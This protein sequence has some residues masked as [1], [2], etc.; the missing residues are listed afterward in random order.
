M[1]SVA[2]EQSSAHIHPWP[3][4]TRTVHTVRVCIHAMHRGCRKQSSLALEDTSELNKQTFLDDELPQLSRA[5]LESASSI[6]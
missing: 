4:T 1:V 5:H 2:R 3:W 6:A